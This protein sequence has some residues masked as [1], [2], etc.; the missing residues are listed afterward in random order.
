M[1]VF[2]TLDRIEQA[3]QPQLRTLKK[4]LMA[5]LVGISGIVGLLLPSLQ[6]VSVSSLQ[7]LTGVGTLS[8]LVGFIGLF[9][10]RTWEF[11]RYELLPNRSGR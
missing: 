8:L 3:Y 2:E 9:I 11:A 5:G 10:W 6:S 7:S 1:G 4:Q